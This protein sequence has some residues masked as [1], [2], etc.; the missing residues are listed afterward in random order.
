[1]NKKIQK[2]THIAYLGTK[3]HIDSSKTKMCEANNFSFR[4]L[5]DNVFIRLYFHQ[6]SVSFTDSSLIIYAARC[7]ISLN[8][9]CFMCFPK[10]LCGF[11]PFFFSV[12]CTSNQSYA[13]CLLWT[14]AAMS[15]ALK[16]TYSLFDTIRIGR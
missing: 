2:H 1:M 7:L 11:N 5:M 9:H 8:L 4:F 6:S 16:V 14:D 10:S 13:P 15:N 3:A 12:A